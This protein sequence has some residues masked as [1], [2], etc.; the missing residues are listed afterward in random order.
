MT[1]QTIRH[2]VIT[3]R[4][5]LG[6]SNYRLAKEAGI[7]SQLVYRWLESGHADHREHITTETLQPI[8][9]ALGLK[10]KP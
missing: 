9:G 4:D 1:Q 10:I 7:A 5:T 6:W 8:L 3:R 2:K